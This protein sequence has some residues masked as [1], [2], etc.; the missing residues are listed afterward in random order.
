MTLDVFESCD[1][2]GNE[3]EASEQ[4]TDLETED[5]MMEEGQPMTPMQTVIQGVLD[6]LKANQ[7]HFDD[8]MDAF[9]WGDKGCIQDASIRNT[10]TR[11]LHSEKL[12]II[13]KRWA[14]PPRTETSKKKQPEGGS[15]SV[16]EFALQYVQDL[17]DKELEDLAPSMLSPTS[18]DVEKATL[19]DTTFAN[20][21]IAIKSK[22]PYLY[23]VVQSL[24]WRSSQEKRN[25]HKTPANML[26]Y[27][28]SHHRCRFQKLLAI[29]LKFKGISAKGFDT[30]HA[31]A[32][33]MSHKW[34]SDAVPQISAKSMEEVKEMIKCYAWLVSYDNV[35][36][37]FRAFSQRVDHNTNFSSGTA[38]TVYIKPNAPPLSAAANQNLR[39]KRAEGLL[40]PL[41]NK[42]IT[43]LATKSY[44]HVRTFMIHQVLEF[45][46][47]CPEFECGSYPNKDDY[48]FK[49]PPAIRKLPAGP[50][51]ITRQYMLGT[52]GIAEASYKDN[53]RLIKEWFKQLGWASPLERLKVATSKVV[54]W[55][56]DQLT[57][58]RLC[59][60]FKFRARDENSFERLDY[61]VFAFG[62]LHCRMAFANSLHKQY[63]GTSQGRGL[64]H[65]FIL[66]SKKGLNTAKTEGPFFNDLTELLNHVAEVHILEDWL[67]AGQKLA[68]KIVNTRASSHALTNLS[69]KYPDKDLDEAF[70]QTI[71]FNRDVL[72][73]LV[74][75]RAIKEG[76]VGLMEDM[77][78]HLYFRFLGGG[79]G[80]YAI[81]MLETMQ[82][83]YREWDEE[84]A[85]D[86]NF[87]REH[88]WVI[89]MTGRPEDWCK[90]D[91]AQ[92]FNI[93]GIKVTYRSEGPNIC[94]DYM[95]KLHPAIH[96]IRAV[97]DHIEKEY[98]TYTRGKKHTSPS[99]DK[100]VNKLR[101]AYC[102][103]GYHSYTGGRR[104]KKEDL[105]KDVLK[106][107]F[108]KLKE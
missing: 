23:R 61:S 64:M 84:I 14:K 28:R 30:L 68:K 21:D 55:I 19:L 107:G 82:G 103:A 26:F 96:V 100:D 40:N 66:L 25:V 45:L 39:K 27:S 8:F 42:D 73:Y 93:K 5:E 91:R 101:A 89:N 31:M 108:L 83:L 38:A 88:C 12:P 69:L 37:S 90:I 54:A 36:I 7:V 13:L 22:A 2:A 105:A 71:M 102:E 43:D 16:K 1:I 35:N 17:F 15:K 58:D 81:E 53:E 65:T 24:T 104:L 51:N 10:R 70:H 94:W 98:G 34:T 47:R 76:D 99:K 52:V 11:F 85:A 48:R 49:P 50:T 77:L 86:R 3:S 106:E 74:L 75:N 29:Y 60:L 92:E 18:E 20:L 62:W 33:T 6:L 44:P 80:R 67:L 63:L 32:L 41:S 87:V 97:T 72:Q 59:G 78:P 57:M 9:S 95:T 56:G 4:E 79:N 46:I